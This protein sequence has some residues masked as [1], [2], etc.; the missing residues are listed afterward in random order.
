MEY[1]LKYLKYKSKY[2][3]LKKILGKN[4]NY[5]SDKQIG[6]FETISTDNNNFL[7]NFDEVELFGQMNC[8]IYISKDNTQII[9]CQNSTEC[10]SEDKLKK[11]KLIKIHY[12]DYKIFPDIYNCYIYNDKSYI[13]MEKF[14]GDLTKLLFELLPRHILEKMV[15]DRRLLPEHVEKYYQLF[16]ILFPK[17]SHYEILSQ[18]DCSNPL[19]AYLN[20][21]RD[22]IEQIEKICE[23]NISIYRKNMYKDVQLIKYK[24]MEVGKYISVFTNPLRTLELMTKFFQDGIIK[25]P[26]YMYFIEH[27]KSQFSIIFEQVKKQIYRI[28]LLLMKI[29]L[30]YTD[31]KTD[32]YVYMLEDSNHPHLGVNWSSNLIFG[33]KYF[34]ISVIDWDSGLSDLN[35]WT[36][37]NFV[38]QFN[39]YN[40]TKY[41]QY[42]LNTICNNCPILVNCESNIYGL[43]EDGF[44]ILQT[45]Y[46]MEIPNNNFENISQ[47]NKFVSEGNE[48]IDELTF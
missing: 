37:N 20:T 22:E 45:D 2:I 40:P 11:L 9:K 31:D 26:I 28:K 15:E 10:I 36:L 47:I 46:N 16:H 17:T 12:P 25:Y 19:I 39:K 33:N 4:L 1:K 6:G 32:N 5:K 34:F 38:S 23:D 18:V 48:V 24:D 3:Q 13:L 43:D 21:H 27:F 41:G 44:Q 35:T 7:E 14:S 29:G 42:Y 30:A 8:G